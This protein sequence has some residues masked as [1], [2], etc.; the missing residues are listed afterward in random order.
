MTTYYHDAYQIYEI[1]DKSYQVPPDPD[2][3][4]ELFVRRPSEAK[5]KFVY[6][7]TLLHKAFD[8][9]SHKADVIDVILE[10]YPQALETED[11]NGYLP[12]HRLLSGRWGDNIKEMTI[13]IMNAFPDSLLAPTSV[14]GELPLHIASQRT[15]S[16]DVVELLLCFPDACQY[17]DH[18]GKF[19]FDHALEIRDPHPAI[20][21]LLLKHYPVLLSFPDANGSLKIHRT[22]EKCS[23]LQKSSYD[24]VIEI[25][26]SGCEASLRVQD[27]S[28]YTP[29]LL[30]CTQNHSLSQIY[31]LVRK[32]PE[33]VTPNR[34]KNI[35]DPFVFNG[36]LLYP[37]LVSGTT[38][39]PN[40]KKWLLQDPDAR[41]RR[42]LYGRLPLHY[43]VISKSKKAYEITRCLLFGREEE[44]SP[45]ARESYCIQQLSAKD[46]GGRLPIHMASASPYCEP[47]IL[48]LL[49]ELYSRGL[50]KQDNG[51]RLPWHYGECSRQDL[52]FE[53]TANIFPDMDVDLDL[54]PEEI[55]WDI[56]SVKGH[57]FSN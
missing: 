27:S 51:G 52:V 3:M 41:F 55:Q 48:T 46:N 44:V 16:V 24:E 13:K 15:E 35:F 29:L 54:V 34:S 30:A 7:Q 5:R 4:Q 53:S 49:I 25:L 47:E 31:S 12:M 17:R 37:S 57:D 40:V 42:D 19:P 14:G 20:L 2:A 56:L 28:G 32:W 33:Q 9:F 38:K 11:E 23:L 22:L 10:A 36:E 50:M 18:H 8:F 6:G 26:V 21:Q 1:L 45:E 39:L 43:A